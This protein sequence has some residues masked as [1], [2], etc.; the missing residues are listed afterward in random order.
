MTRKYLQVVLL[1]DSW[2]WSARTPYGR[3]YADFLELELQII[4]GDQWVV[5]VAACGDGGWFPGF[6]TCLERI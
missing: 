3:R 5:D 1:G 4:M 2:T 6:R